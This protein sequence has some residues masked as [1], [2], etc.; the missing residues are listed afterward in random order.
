LTYRPASAVETCLIPA[1]R[2]GTT[3]PIAID[4]LGIGAQE[5]PSSLE[6]KSIPCGKSPKSTS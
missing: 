5:Q 2:V 4:P 3:N 1:R 6:E